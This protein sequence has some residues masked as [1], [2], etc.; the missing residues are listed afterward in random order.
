MSEI[1]VIFQ[2]TQ[3]FIEE[4]S[5]SYHQGI[6]NNRFRC[7]FCYTSRFPVQRYCCISIARLID[8]LM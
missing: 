3:A 7:L 6:L 1:E 4:S 2:E 8:A 5:Q